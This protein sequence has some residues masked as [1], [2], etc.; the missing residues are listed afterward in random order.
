MFYI[1]TQHESYSCKRV[2]KIK[3]NI[4]VSQQKILSFM[5]ESALEDDNLSMYQMETLKFEIQ[6][7]V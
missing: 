1:F 5:I 6:D 4:A 2:L 3:I 7:N